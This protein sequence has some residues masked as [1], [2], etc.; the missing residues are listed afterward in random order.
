M[1]AKV[2]TLM[3]SFALLSSA[4]AYSKWVPLELGE[5][6]S[7]TLE[8]GDGKISK[9]SDVVLFWARLRYVLDGDIQENEIEEGSYLYR[10]HADCV[11]KSY[12]LV[13][14]ATYKD[15]KNKKLTSES[16]EPTGVITAVEGTFNDTAINAVCKSLSQKK[17]VIGGE[18]V[19]NHG[20][21][22][23]D[24]EVESSDLTQCFPDD[25]EWV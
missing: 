12:E 1:N 18:S 3:A 9:V 22:T 24:Y 5:I 10:I 23:N 13:Y 20:F 8:F 17:A 15:T 7:Y 6:Q 11:T 2:L 19:K 25:D 16:H 14:S 4:P 21:S